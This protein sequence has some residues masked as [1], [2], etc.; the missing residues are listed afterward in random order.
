MG[1]EQGIEPIQTMRDVESFQIPPFGSPE[2][3]LRTPPYFK[4]GYK[5]LEVISSFP[6]YSNR[7]ATAAE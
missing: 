7:A 1:K 4:Q 3:L 2:Y 5:L 6:A